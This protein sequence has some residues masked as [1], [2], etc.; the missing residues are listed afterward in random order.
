MT[1]TVDDLADDLFLA[2]FYSLHNA[3]VCRDAVPMR[4]LSHSARCQ[5]WACRRTNTN[6][7]RLAVVRLAVDSES[8]RERSLGGGPIACDGFLRGVINRH[9]TPGKI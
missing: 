6:V 8:R 1:E 7:S 9:M 5:R 4:S 2:D 3:S